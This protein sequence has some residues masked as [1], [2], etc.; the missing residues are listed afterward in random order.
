MEASGP[1]AIMQIARKEDLELWKLCCLL[2]SKLEA[3]QKPDNPSEIEFEVRRN[4]LCSDPEWIDSPGRRD[5][6]RDHGPVLPLHLY[7]G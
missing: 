4:L 2:R 5:R 7:P 1:P 6:H 3:M